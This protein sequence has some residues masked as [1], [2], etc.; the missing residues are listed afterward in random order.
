VSPVRR[1]LVGGTASGKKTVAAALA[2]E[3]GLTLLSMDSMKVYRGMDIGTDKP[4]A[5][6][7]S[8]QPFGLLDLVGHDERFSA[9][10]WVQ[11]A[12]AAV[13]ASAAPVLFAGGTPLYLR[14]LLRGLFP[15]PPA[16]HALR[17]E[18][19]ARWDEQGEAALRA[20]L[21]R[22]DPEAEA[23]LSPRDAKRVLRALEV[24]RLTGRTLTDWQ[25]EETRPPIAGRFLVAALRHDPEVHARRIEQRV[26]LMLERGL[27]EEV[28]ALA[29]QAPFAPEPARAI[30]YHEA[31]EHLA[32]RMDR[33]TML[34][35]IARRTR[36]LVRKQ[37][38]FIGSHDQVRWVDVPPGTD[39]A[40]VTQRVAE[41]L[42][43]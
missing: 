16:D 28:A 5:V 39:P 27:L 38:T 43:L 34:E 1:V 19:Q 33:P 13:Q 18:L 23:R 15:G 17:A 14:L 21:A 20:E 6:T 22:L 24:V 42:E 32:G 9:G 31:L 3:H 40:A 10:M 11:H 41:L 35:T 7:P 2:A 8:E 30:G 37:R 26:Q 12:V 25:R 36:K 4:G 29:A